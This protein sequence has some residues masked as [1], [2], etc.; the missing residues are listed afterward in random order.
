MTPTEETLRELCAYYEWSSP[1]NMAAA[2]VLQGAADALKRGELSHEA[3][4][5]VAAVFDPSVGVEANVGNVPPT[6]IIATDDETLQRQ[7]IEHM[8]VMIARTTNA[9]KRIHLVRLMEKQI[10][11]FVGR[12]E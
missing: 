8:R 6:Y 4:S 10:Q 2:D 1:P 7:I 12:A 3:A 9:A 5:M 11:N